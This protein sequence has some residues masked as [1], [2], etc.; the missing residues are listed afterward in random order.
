MNILFIASGNDYQ[1]DMLFHGLHELSG[2]TV[3][4]HSDMWYMFEG[5]DPAKVSGLYGKGFSLYNRINASKR[6]EPSSTIREKIKSKFYD[7]IIYGHIHR[8]SEYLNDVLDVYSP[9]EIVFV[10]GED[11]DFHLTR[12]LKSM[13]K[14]YQPPFFQQYRDAITLSKKG[15][16]FKREL[17]NCDS[18]YFYPISFAIPEKNIIAEPLPDKTRD[19]ASIIPGNLS[20]YI[21]NTEAEY[22]RGYAIS[23]YA[24]TT[25][26]AGWDCLRH[27]EILANNCIP[28]FP[29]IE[30]CPT[31]TMQTF[32]KTIIMETNKLIERGK[33]QG[34][35]FE[36]YSHQLHSYTKNMLT[37]KKVAEYV[38]SKV[39]AR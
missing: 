1:C 37:T 35:L 20:T 5:N 8:C 38:L 9:Q 36:D 39:S 19:Q 29:H 28:Y 27:Y 2:V 3:Y 23:K 11:Y 33:L 34:V 18:K 17:R 30:K 7:C 6:I 24:I 21:Y 4:T 31:F 10:D 13:V 15:I 22:Y 26:R 12:R 32:P 14:K 16:Y 25:K